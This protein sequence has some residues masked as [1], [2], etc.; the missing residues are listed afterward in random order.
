MKQSIKDSLKKRVLETVKDK[1]EFVSVKASV[2]DIN[3][4]K[5]PVK[6]YKLEGGKKNIN[7]FDVI[8]FRI[9]QDWY[10]KLRQHSNRPTGVKKGFL[11]Y[12]LEV[13][14]HSLGERGESPVLCLRSAFG[15]KCCVCDENQKQRDLFAKTGKASHEKAAAALRTKWRVFYTINIGTTTKPKLRLLDHS[16]MLFEKYLKESA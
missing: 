5:K 9:T 10:E 13:P 11:D 4:S 1:D 6:F 8:P 16:F 12:K 2:L 14:I 3:K 15:K 7:R